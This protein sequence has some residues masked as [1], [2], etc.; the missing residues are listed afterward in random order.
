VPA[1]AGFRMR[2]G[3]VLRNRWSVAMAGIGRDGYVVLVDDAGTEADR[4]GRVGELLADSGAVRYAATREFDEMICRGRFT[5]ARRAH[6]PEPYFPA[7]PGADDLPW[8][9]VRYTPDVPRGAD[10][11]SRDVPAALARG[12]WES[13][14][15]TC[16]VT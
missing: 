1:P 4:L 12:E 15:V 6:E 10:V 13:V 2:N 7:V 14:A 3:E 9:N 5:N 11:L 8:L 16:C